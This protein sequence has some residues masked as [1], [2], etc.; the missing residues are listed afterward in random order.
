MLCEA[1]G[2]LT[3]SVHPLS[4][5]P[6]AVSPSGLDPKDMWVLFIFVTQGPGEGG[7]GLK[8]P[9]LSG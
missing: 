6:M 5:F 1:L 3:L 2:P 8:K 9:V 7:Q 4:Q